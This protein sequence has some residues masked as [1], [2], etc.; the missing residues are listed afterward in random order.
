MVSEAVPS[1]SSAVANS[2][3][4]VAGVGFMALAKIKYTLS[5]YSTPKRFGPR[6]AVWP[7]PVRGMVGRD[8]RLRG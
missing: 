5:G 4:Y 6:R 3:Y 8:A 2:L 1:R 7:Q